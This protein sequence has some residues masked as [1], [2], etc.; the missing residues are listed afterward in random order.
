MKPTVKRA[1]GLTVSIAGL[2]GSVAILAT[3]VDLAQALGLLATAH[4]GWLAA[5]AGMTLM[6]PVL[7]GLKL[8]LVLRLIDFRAP[9]ARA[10]SA[11]LAAVTLNAVV[12]GRGGDFVRAA[13]LADDPATLSLL[14]GAVLVERLID[15]FV[16][17][18]M[19]GV[20]SL[21]GDAGIVPLVAL[22]TCAAAVAAL[23]ALGL[24]HK[25]PVRKDTAERAGRA[26]RALIARPGL[27][28]AIL[29]MT[30]VCWA[31]NVATM[32]LSLRAVGAVIPTWAVYRATPVAVLTGILPLSINGVGTRDAAML[33]L[34]HDHGQREA[35]IA[36][37]VAYFLLNGWFLAV[38]GLAALGRETLRRV[39]GRAD[40]A[41]ET[42]A[43]E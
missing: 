37:T 9:L 35:V 3:Q 5:A 15:V 22:G 34:L 30:V 16:L 21:G 8:L 36:G 26:A 38:L 1:L 23:V 29:A 41:R 4:R 2:A 40:A 31:N 25:L 17:G 19:A 42:P 43:A 6:A 10:W 24:G 33:Y 11:V 18:A 7:V 20:A 39:R 32:D 28:A 13:F 14:V 12:P 27:T